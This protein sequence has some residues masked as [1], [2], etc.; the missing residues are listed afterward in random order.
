MNTIIFH[1][2]RSSEE[3]KIMYQGNFYIELVYTTMPMRYYP[4]SQLGVVL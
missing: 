1:I 2:Q 3:D 4:T